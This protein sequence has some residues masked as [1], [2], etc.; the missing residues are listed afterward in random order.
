MQLSGRVALIGLAVALFG[1]ACQ[2]DV[3]DPGD[4]DA[5]IFPV[6][7]V[8][9]VKVKPGTRFAWT[10]WPGIARTSEA[11]GRSCSPGRVW[12][13]RWRRWITGVW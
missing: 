10:R 8:V 7:D 1:I 2:D 11:R 4:P 3:M 12:I 9:R 6:E 13:Q 5:A